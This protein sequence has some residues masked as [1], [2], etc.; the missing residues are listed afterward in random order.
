MISA[1]GCERSRYDMHFLRL[2]SQFLQVAGK[3]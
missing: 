1:E 3:K 2:A